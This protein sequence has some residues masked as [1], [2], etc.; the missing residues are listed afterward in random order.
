M[1]EII[2]LKNLVWNE[3]QIIVL[4]VPVVEFWHLI[5]IDQKWKLWKELYA[6]TFDV[7]F[8]LFMG[9]RKQ[10]QNHFG[11]KLFGGLGTALY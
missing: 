7:F 9:L 2:L 10:V 3:L 5:K 8:Q 11:T 4:E 1:K 6:L